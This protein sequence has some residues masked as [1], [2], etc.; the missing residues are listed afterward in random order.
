MKLSNTSL[1]SFCTLPLR[2]FYAFNTQTALKSL[3]AAL[4]CATVFAFCGLFGFAQMHQKQVSLIWENR[5]L[6]L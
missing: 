5:L 1:R 2:S 3:R 6:H 4:H